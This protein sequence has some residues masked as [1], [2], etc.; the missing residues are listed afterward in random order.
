MDESL[1]VPAPSSGRGLLLA[2]GLTVL[3]LAVVAA[4]GL[5]LYGRS[6]PCEGCLEKLQKDAVD[7]A[8]ATA[9]AAAAEPD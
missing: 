6:H 9:R 8:E 5:T 2:V 1:P 3:L 7:E 4:V